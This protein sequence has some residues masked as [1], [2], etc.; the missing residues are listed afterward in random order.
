MQKSDV[1][2]IIA[3]IPLESYSVSQARN[4]KLG[5]ETQC[6]YYYW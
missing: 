1:L 4:F 5:Q 6:S 3:G 2:P